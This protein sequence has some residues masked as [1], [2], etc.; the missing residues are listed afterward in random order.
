MSGHAEEDPSVW[1]K[2]IAGELVAIRTALEELK[3]AST[4]G[5]CDDA[6]LIA[7]S[8]MSMRDAVLRGQFISQGLPPE[9]I[10]AFLA[11]LM[12]RERGV[13][14]ID[15]RLGHE[16]AD[17]RGGGLD[18]LWCL[19]GHSSLTSHSVIPAKRVERAQSRDPAHALT[20]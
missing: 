19:D 17:R 9:A 18:R 8:I 4:G 2:Q 20:Y 15:L 10:K 3:P 13:E 11:V 16:L 12:R 6:T 5:K 1:L 7:L 14:R